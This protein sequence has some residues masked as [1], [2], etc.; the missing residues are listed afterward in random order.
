MKILQTLYKSLNSS[1]ETTIAPVSI[2]SSSINLKVQN[3]RSF[4][5]KK[6][7]EIIYL[8]VSA[9]YQEILHATTFQSNY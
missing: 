5:G 4:R 9:R 7:M 1:L 3:L 6:L 2:A 8:L